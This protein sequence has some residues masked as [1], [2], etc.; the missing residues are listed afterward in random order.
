MIIPIPTYIFNKNISF[1]RQTINLLSYFYLDNKK[2]HSLKLQNFLNILKYAH[3]FQS[4]S[5]AATKRKDGL[6]AEPA[7]ALEL[8]QSEGVY[9]NCGAA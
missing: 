3:H 9:S 5:P 7:G 4:L 1:V 6:L 8:Q 2:F